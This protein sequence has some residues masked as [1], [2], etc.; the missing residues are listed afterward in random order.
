MTIAAWRVGRGANGQ[1]MKRLAVRTQDY[2]TMVRW[3]ARTRGQRARARHTLWIEDADAP[4][5]ALR[6]TTPGGR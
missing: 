3:L 4:A 1:P 6:T 5:T 2:P